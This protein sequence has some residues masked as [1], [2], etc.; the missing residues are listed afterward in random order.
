MTHKPFY[1]TSTRREAL[2][3]MAAVGGLAAAGS[4]VAPVCSQLPRRP[5][6][7]NQLIVAVSATPVSLDPDTV[8]R[9]R[10]GSSRYSS[11]NICF[12]IT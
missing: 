6:A 9:S 2:K 7:G 1:D 10:A 3:N 8:R 12:V 11:T 4:V 5:S